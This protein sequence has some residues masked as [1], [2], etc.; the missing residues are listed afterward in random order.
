MEKCKQKKILV[1]RY[2]FLGDT[3]LT[4]PV[5]RALSSKKDAYV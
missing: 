5:F 1:L 2:R 3:I 4:V